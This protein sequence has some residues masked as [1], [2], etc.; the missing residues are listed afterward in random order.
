MNKPEPKAP[1]PAP[2]P[3]VAPPAPAVHSG[4]I[5]SRDRQTGRLEIKT[6]GKLGIRWRTPAPAGPPVPAAEK[7]IGE[8]KSDSPIKETAYKNH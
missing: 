8:K 1:K 6:T 2:K 3:E 5:E 7:T 4:I